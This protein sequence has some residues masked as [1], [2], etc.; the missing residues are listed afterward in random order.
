MWQGL[1]LQNLRC[2]THV[3][4]D[5]L[6]VRVHD[7]AAGVIVDGVVFPVPRR[8]PQ[9]RVGAAVPRPVLQ[10][11]VVVSVAGVVEPLGVHVAV[12][13]GVRVQHVGLPVPAL[14]IRAGPPH[15]SAHVG[16]R[17]RARGVHG[18]AS[19][20]RRRRIRYPRAA[21]ASSHDGVAARSY[22]YALLGR[23]PSLSRAS[24]APA[25]VTRRGH[26]YASHDCPGTHLLVLVLWCTQWWSKYDGIPFVACTRQKPV[27][28]CDIFNRM[29]AKHVL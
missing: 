25:S 29:F 23:A 18:A 20:A 13:R 27:I 7:L 26:A 12:A 4:V 16:L 1:A 6:G 24:V 8:V 19:T 9:D 17:R 15:R 14:V 22:R 21:P 5:H 10:H 28:F 2:R 3:A 11:R